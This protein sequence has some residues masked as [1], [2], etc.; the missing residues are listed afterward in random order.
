MALHAATD[1]TARDNLGEQFIQPGPHRQDH[2]GGP[3]TA[4]SAGQVSPCGGA[5]AA[6]P[7][8]GPP[9]S[10]VLL[11]LKSKTSL[12]PSD[13]PAP[14]GCSNCTCAGVH[15][16]GKEQHCHAILCRQCQNSALG[17][18]CSSIDLSSTASSSAILMPSWDRN[19]DPVRLNP[20]N[21]SQPANLGCNGDHQHCCHQ[22]TSMHFLDRSCLLSCMQDLGLWLTQ[23]KAA[24]S[25]AVLDSDMA[26]WKTACMVTLGAR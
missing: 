14:L 17:H 16:I 25:R 20:C 12:G 3:H 13:A 9:R 19:S 1:A 11:P 24:A 22:A 7:K 18:S 10:R 6:F 4:F 26:A 21:R 15:S 8:D 23:R 5:A 2:T